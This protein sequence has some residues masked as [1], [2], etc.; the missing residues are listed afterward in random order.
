[1]PLQRGNCLVGVVLD[2][3]PQ[4]TINFC[5]L[6]SLFHVFFFSPLVLPAFFLD[7]GEI[8]SV[9]ISD[10][11]RSSGSTK[12]W[13]P[14]FWFVFAF[15]FVNFLPFPYRFLYGLRVPVS[16]YFKVSGL[17]PPSSDI[18][19]CDIKHG[20]SPFLAPPLPPSPSMVIASP[21]LAKIEQLRF[22]DPTFLGA[23][24]SHDHL[25]VSSE[26]YQHHPG[27]CKDRLLFH[28]V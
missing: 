12:G 17:T 4:V 10:L 6:F 2:S 18:P 13:F 9:S 27:G 3:R 23:G 26:F 20:T 14:C 11:L 8:C 5:F 24:E 19:V 21:D 1:M 15:S 22:F 25:L 28:T 16:F 7:L